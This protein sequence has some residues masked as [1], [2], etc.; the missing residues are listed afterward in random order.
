MKQNFSLTFT[1]VPPAPLIPERLSQYAKEVREISDKRSGAYERGEDALRLPNDPSVLADVTHMVQKYWNTQL[2][3]VI[4]IGIGGSN[5]GAKA[6]YDALRGTLDGILDGFPK[7]IFL[8]TVSPKLLLDIERILEIEVSYKEEVV[9]NLISKSG[10]T[11]ESIANF[12]IIHGYLK[13]RFPAIGERIVVTTDKDSPLW[14]I[15]EKHKFGTL[16]HPR[17]GGRFSVFSSVGLLPLGLAGIDI[18]GLVD[19]AKAALSECREGS[20]EAMRFAEALY[21]AKKHEVTAVNFFFFNPELESLGKWARQLYGESLGK[22]HDKRGKLVREGITPI[23][24][25]GSADLHSMAQLYLGGPKDKFTLF[26]HVKE[27]SHLRVPS[28]VIFKRVIEGINGKGPDEL[29]DAIYTGVKA[30]Y[31]KHKLPTA[32]VTFPTVNAYMVGM[33]MSWQM[34]SVMYLAELLGV[35]AFD[36]PNVEDYKQV[37]KLI[38]EH[39][40]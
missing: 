10:S 37:T 29:M 12:E 34:L 7:L 9:I 8:D 32:E 2:R 14:A 16:L 26:M 39:S 38:L 33:F 20:D 18:V 15:A 11:T 5:L 1:N 6:V 31:A 27:A 17:V 23:V 36:Q 22:E 30:A 40:R 3:Y 13:K 28:S 19:G 25:I 21:R 35:N 4:V 24:T